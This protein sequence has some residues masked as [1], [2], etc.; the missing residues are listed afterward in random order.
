MQ[1][2]EDGKILGVLSVLRKDF[3]FS[4]NPNARK[5]GLIGIAATGIVLGQ[6][7][8]QA[9]IQA[10]KQALCCFGVYAWGGPC[11]WVCCLQVYLG[12]LV[13]P[14]L[15]CFTD[16]DSRVRYYACEALYNISKIARGDILVFFNRIFDGLAKLAADPEPR[17][18]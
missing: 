18:V 2:K 3:V 12:E 16:T 6:L 9:N 17:S 1:T 4:T 5:G 15:S 7:V 8:Q 13:P 10:S 11:P 14:I